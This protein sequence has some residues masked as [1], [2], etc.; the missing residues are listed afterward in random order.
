MS[1][2]KEEETYLDTVKAAV[3][4]QQAA[5]PEPEPAPKEQPEEKPADSAAAE[6]EPEAHAKQEARERDG[7]GRFKAKAPQDE[8]DK[9][10]EDKPEEPEEAVQPE[11]GKPD[12]TRPPRRLPLRTRAAWSSLPEAA[13]EDIILRE[14][15]FDKAFKRYDGLGQFAIKAEQN[16]TTLHQAVA[17]YHQMET[18]IRQ[19]PIRGAIQVWQAAGHDPRAVLNDLARQL[20]P[21]AEGQPQQQSPPMQM[22][23]GM[24]REEGEQWLH[25]RFIQ[26]DIESKLAAFEADPRHSYLEPLIPGEPLGPI[27][28]AMVGIMQSVPGLAEDL[29]SAYSMALK[30]HGIDPGTRPNGQAAPGGQAK[31][32]AAVDRS[33]QAAKAAIG[34]PSQGSNAK[35]RAQDDG[36]LNWIDTVKAAYNK[37]RGE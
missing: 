7:S 31:A 4:S 20:T 18:L 23:Q 30:A 17:S 25:Q 14:Q 6:E 22:P 37:A 21:P 13:R 11:E 36:N 8:A 16:G 3:E 29:E 26:R 10:P 33:R 32:A 19:D 2:E 24:T 27:R 34:A 9:L 1:E 15:E 28:G 12:I 5:A 35:E